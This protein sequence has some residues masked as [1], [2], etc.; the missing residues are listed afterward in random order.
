MSHPQSPA[1]ETLPHHVGPKL[2]FG[3]AVKTAA[4]VC[5]A[6]GSSHWKIHREELGLARPK[7]SKDSSDKPIALL[8]TALLEEPEPQR[9]ARL[10]SPLVHLTRVEPLTFRPTCNIS[11]IKRQESRWTVSDQVSAAGEEEFVPPDVQLVKQRQQKITSFLST[12]SPVRTHSYTPTL[13]EGVLVRQVEKITASDQN[14]KVDESDVLKEL[15]PNDINSPTGITATCRRPIRGA[16]GRPLKSSDL[17]NSENCLFSPKTTKTSSS[18]SSYTESCTVNRV[19]SLPPSTP[20]T[21]FTSST[22][23]SSFSN[24]SSRLLSAAPPAGPTKAERRG[25]SLWIK[26]FLLAIVAAFLFLVYQAM[27]TNTI[28]PFVGSDTDVAS[29]SAA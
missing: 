23:T 9:S 11:P 29:S 1:G 10:S 18:S 16:A 20:S 17:W 13:S 19:T 26:L 28:N 27:E 21:S 2:K 25:M 14:L 7:H 22:S 4:E 12:C 15:F 3:P 6:A 8:N 5:R 24:S